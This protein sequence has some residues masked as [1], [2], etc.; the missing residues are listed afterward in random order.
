MTPRRPCGEGGAGAAWVLRIRKQSKRKHG[1]VMRIRKQ[2]KPGVRTSKGP[3]D[4]VM[5][6]RIGEIRQEE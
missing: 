5:A 4:E 2:S 1:G 6:R 3:E